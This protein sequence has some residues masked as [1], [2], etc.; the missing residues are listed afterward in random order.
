MVY[1]YQIMTYEAGRDGTERQLSAR[2]ALVLQI[3]LQITA[4]VNPI[5]S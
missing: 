1:T 3:L 2:R 5:Q 4:Q